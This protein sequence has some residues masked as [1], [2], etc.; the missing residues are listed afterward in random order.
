MRII[1]VIDLLDGCAVHA[2]RG[3]RATY[4][5]VASA[6]INDPNP[7][8]VLDAYLSIFPFRTI[9]VA[10]L[11][12]IQQTG[13]NGSAVR[14][15][16]HA[17]PDQEFWIDAGL[18]SAHRAEPRVRPVLGTETG[19]SRGYFID[20]ARS[21]TPPV[22]SL[23]FVDSTLLGDPDILRHPE[24]WPTDIIVMCL[25]RI[26]TEQG[27]ALDLCSR[28]NRL[29]RGRNKI[30][31]AGGVRDANDLHEAEAAGAAGALV[32]TALHNRTLSASALP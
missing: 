26:G 5:P 19:I 18:E 8:A 1:P 9:Y 14:A 3:Q 24:Y 29:G 15:L 20:A 17:F 30:Y 11:N 10:D 6:L 7:A 16:L 13:D 32:A 4:R 21:E 12:A 2:W 28:I 23:D 25:R 31:L 27:P 22:L